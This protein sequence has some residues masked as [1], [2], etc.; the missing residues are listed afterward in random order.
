MVEGN[1]VR[2]DNDPD[3]ILRDVSKK[4]KKNPWMVST[5]VLIIAGIVLLL[6]NGGIPTG[7][8]ISPDE[9]GQ[10]IIDFATAQGAQA[11]LVEVNEQDNFY[12]VIL[13][14]QGQE[15]PLYVTKDGK[16]FAQALVPLDDDSGAP[17]QL[18]DTQT[19]EPS[20]DVSI[21]DDAVKG[22]PNAPVTIIEFSDYECPFCG[23]HFRD[24]LPQIIS[25]YVDTGKVK[26]V[27]RDFPLGFHDDAQKAS[28]AAECAGEQGD[29]NYWKM[30]DKLFENQQTLDE[31][32]LKQYA[33]DIGLDTV[34]FDSCLD[35]DAMEDEV[36]ADMEDGKIYG[37]SGTPAFFINGKFIS[38]AQPFSVFKDIIDAELAK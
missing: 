6:V 28:E 21:D 10:K 19:Q 22:D 7:A 15:L 1:E 38:G 24:T 20:V 2:I 35:S 14:M 36:K 30:H 5:I 33:K 31:D 18:P 3:K 32:S 29:E 8:K 34:Q 16:Y 25:E 23:R 17:S 37:V 13:S 26:I 12:E 4:F 27:F 11:T 9:A